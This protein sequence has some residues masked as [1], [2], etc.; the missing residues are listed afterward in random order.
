METHTSRSK[1]ASF[2]RILTI[3]GTRPEAI[4]MAPVIREIKENR[5]GIEVLVG[6]TSQHREMLDQVLNRF[7]IEPDFDLDLMTKNQTPSEIAARVLRAMD[8]ILADLQP[9]VLLVQG[10]TTT[11]MAASIAAF[12]RSIRTGHLEAGLRTYDRANPFPE[13][14]N[15]VVADHVCSIHFAPTSRARDNLLREG[16]AA[17]NVF[18]TGN[19]V[20]DALLWAK[21]Q[22]LDGLVLEELERSGLIELVSTEAHPFIL[23]T[24]H[25]RES[26]GQPIRQIC[27]ALR[28]LAE[29]RP[30]WGIIYP[31]HR[32]P[33][34][35]NPVH[36]LLE[37][38]PGIHLIPPV[39]YFTLI[40]L[41]KKS[42]LILTDSGGI[43]EEAPSLGTPV[44]VL[45]K[46]TERPE[47][48]EAGVVRLVGTEPEQII[49]HTNRLIDDKASYHSMARFINPYGDGLAA[50][51]VVD[52][53]ATGQ[54]QEFIA[55]EAVFSTPAAAK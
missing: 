47:A 35:W 5:S 38:V 39:D 44:L 3:I 8:P 20:I 23:V 12:H 11:V 16:I 4:K 49:S 21:S 22:P 27:E 30:D 6:S 50:E 46:T 42:Y 24:A 9:D 2:M 48:V 19:T 25:R 18:V 34:I 43:Q 7:R 41:M 40:Y 45:R 14:M 32:N 31:V 15:R 53:L 52:V 37:E 28:R 33:N 51:R 54:C 1:K 13:E 29:S 26:H 36:D 17:D 10:D 55:Q